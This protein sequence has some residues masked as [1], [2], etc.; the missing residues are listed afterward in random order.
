MIALAS[1]FEHIVAPATNSAKNVLPRVAALL[2]VMVIQTL[3]M[4]LTAVRLSGQ[5]MPEMP[6]RQ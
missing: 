3:Q 2:D 6:F 5:F 4:L 1:D